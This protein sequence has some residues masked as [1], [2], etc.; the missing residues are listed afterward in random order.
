MQPAMAEARQFN[1]IHK[2]LQKEAPQLIGNICAPSRKT[3][4]DVLVVFR[5]QHVEPES[6]HKLPLNI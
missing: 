5:R 6:H 4:D 1:H 3:F 2:N